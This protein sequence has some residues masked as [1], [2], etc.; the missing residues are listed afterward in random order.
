MEFLSSWVRP[1]ALFATAFDRVDLLS[2]S[3]MLARAGGELEHLNLMPVQDDDMVQATALARFRF[4]ELAVL[5][6][7]A[8]LQS[9][10][11]DLIDVPWGTELVRGVLAYVPDTTRRLRFT[12]EADQVDAVLDALA[13]LALARPHA[14]LQRVEFRRVCLGYVPAEPAYAEILHEVRELAQ[15]KLPARYNEIVEF[16]P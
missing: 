10:S 8:R 5:G 4:A 15:E 16:F 12:L 2:V 1:T 11:V 14:Q 9:V 13:K 3:A 6:Q 7:C